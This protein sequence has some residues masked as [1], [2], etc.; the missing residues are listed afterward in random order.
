MKQITRIVRSN[1]VHVTMNQIVVLVKLKCSNNR[2]KN[3]C[4]EGY[5]VASETLSDCWTEEQYRYFISENS[6]VEVKDKMLGCRVCR[7][8]SE[9][10]KGTQ[11]CAGVNL[12]K[13]TALSEARCCREHP[14][15]SILMEVNVTKVSSHKYFFPTEALGISLYLLSRGFCS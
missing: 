14:S 12:T 11:K 13:E 3:E 10:G 1:A 6:W 5:F 9:V 8:V 7:E 2:D 15:V 4:K